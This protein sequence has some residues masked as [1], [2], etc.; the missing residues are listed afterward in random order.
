MVHTFQSVS[1]FSDSKR[2]LALSDIIVLEVNIIV[3]SQIFLSG[4]YTWAY[5]F[6][7]AVGWHR[8]VPVSGWAEWIILFCAYGL[9]I[10]ERMKKCCAVDDS[11]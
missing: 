1:S 7:G 4:P 9:D 3:V 5:F 2:G 11:M 6:K 10:S 8:G